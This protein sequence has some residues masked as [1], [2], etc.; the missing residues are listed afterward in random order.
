MSVAIL[1]RQAPLVLVLH[2]LLHHQQPLHQHHQGLNMF[3]EINVTT[4]VYSWFS[5]ASL[6][7]DILYEIIEEENE[8]EKEP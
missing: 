2:H 7:V 4:N 5:T 6:D 8:W 1:Q 3:E